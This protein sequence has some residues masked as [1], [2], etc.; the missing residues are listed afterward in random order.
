VRDAPDTVWLLNKT[1]PVLFTCHAPAG[2]GCG[3]AA[4]P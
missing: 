2:S 4:H 3:G 1:L